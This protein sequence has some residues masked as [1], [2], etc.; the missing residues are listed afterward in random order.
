[1]CLKKDNSSCCCAVTIVSALVGAIGIAALFFAGLI[2][3]VISITI[4]TLILGILGLLYVIITNI[5]GNRNCKIIDKL[6]LVPT[7]VGSIVIPSIIL[8]AATIPTGLIAAAFLVGALAFF[9][10]MSLT[11]LLHIIF[12]FF[13]SNRCDNYVE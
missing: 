13:C 2:T 1:M 12:S 8:S 7:I 3:S 9:L 5:C 10:I 6:C 11:N 4:I